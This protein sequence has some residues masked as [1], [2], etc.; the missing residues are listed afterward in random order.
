MHR[1]T[2]ELARHGIT[3]GQV[4]LTVDDVTRRSHHQQ[5]LPH[6]RQA[7]RAGRAARSSTRTTP[8]PPREIRFGDNDRL[9]A[10]VAHLVHADLLRPAQRRRRP[11]RRPRRRR[12]A[13]GCSP[14]C[15]ARRTSTSV[16]DRQAG[17]AGVGT[18]GM[19]TKVEAARIATGAGIPVVLTARR[20]RGRGA[21]RRAG[22]HPVPPHRPAAVDPAAL[23]RARHRGQGHASCST[24]ARS[25]RS[26]TAGPRCCRPGSPRSAGAFVAGDPSTSS[27]PAGAAVARGLVNYDSTELPAMLGRSTRELA[28][29][30]GRGVRA[31]G[32]PPRRPRA[33]V[34]ARPDDGD[35]PSSER[36][37]PRRISAI[38]PATGDG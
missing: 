26:S 4:L 3:A 20:A 18:G 25:A 1:Y 12:P 23:A 37:P 11:L 29:E 15:A 35:I 22:R 24:T 27:T 32:R 17:G 36:V 10:L 13:A 2:E 38:L 34:L 21:G 19:H 16:T 6:L 33:P 9:A 14:R 8:S 7:A 31:G 30:L 5:R 28:R